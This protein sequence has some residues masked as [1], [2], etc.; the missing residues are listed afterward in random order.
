MTRAPHTDVDDLGQALILDQHLE[1]PPG[2]QQGVLVGLRTEDLR[3]VPDLVLLNAHLPVDGVE[4]RSESREL[5]RDPDHDR[6]DERGRDQNRTDGA[7]AP[8]WSTRQPCRA[9]PPTV[10]ALRR[11]TAA[12]PADRPAP[13]QP[14][15]GRAGVATRRRALLASD[16][17]PQGRTVNAH[18]Y[19]SA[20]RLNATLDGAPA[21]P[22]G[23]HAR[24][25]ASTVW[26]RCR[27]GATHRKAEAIPHRCPRSRSRDARR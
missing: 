15:D 7:A 25:S 16:G 12:C 5:E 6:D 26:P 10:P 27:Q 23:T 14:T 13:G 24:A 21:R 2:E 4:G 3:I 17:F 19:L 20:V 1:R 22:A 18:I 11:A 9:A 8:P